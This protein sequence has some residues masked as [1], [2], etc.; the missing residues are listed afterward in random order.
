MLT[1]DE[2]QTNEQSI[3]LDVYEFHPNSV[4]ELFFFGHTVFEMMLWME[5]KILKS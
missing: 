2:A 3:Y 4:I 1:K 5:N